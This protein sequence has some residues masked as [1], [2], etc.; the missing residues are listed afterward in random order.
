MWRRTVSTLCAFLLCISPGMFE[1]G[2]TVV[3]SWLISVSFG[4]LSQA[5]RH[6]KEI[7]SRLN[8]CTVPSHDT[9]GWSGRQGNSCGICGEQRVLGQVATRL[10]L[11]WTVRGCI[12][13]DSHTAH[14]E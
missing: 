10:H 2:L 9:D 8:A 4:K 11:E 3:T 7:M 5:E 12:W 6:C 13:A 14:R 1:S